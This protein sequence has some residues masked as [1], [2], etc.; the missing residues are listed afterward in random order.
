M[1][2]VTAEMVREWRRLAD[3]TQPADAAY[4]SALCAAVPALCDALEA[5]WAERDAALAELAAVPVMQI[6]TVVRAATHVY[7]MSRDRQDVQAIETWLLD[8]ERDAIAAAVDA[9]GRY[10]P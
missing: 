6:N 7:D 3:W 4:I 2:T 5:A 8:R 1:A 10:V 9:E